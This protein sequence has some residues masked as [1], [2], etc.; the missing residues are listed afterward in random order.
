MERGFWRGS[1]QRQVGGVETMMPGRR[2]GSHLHPSLRRRLGG[3]AETML[4][5]GAVAAI[6]ISVSSVMVGAILE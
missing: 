1:L 6:W 3:V 4:L 5:W 2:V